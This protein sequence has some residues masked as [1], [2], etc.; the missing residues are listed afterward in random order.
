MA[1]PEWIFYIPGD[2]PTLVIILPTPNWGDTEKLESKVTVKQDMEGG[3]VT[4]VNKSGKSFIWQF[5]VTKEKAYEVLRLHRLHSRNIIKVETHE[6]VEYLG[7]WTV[8][9]ST[10]MVKGRGQTPGSKEVVQLTI[11]FETIQ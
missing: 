9:P 3:L 4:H 5:D 1:I 7:Y 11:E 6:S 8:N 10:V 2:L